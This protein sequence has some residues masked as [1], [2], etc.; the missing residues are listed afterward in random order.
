MVYVIL[1]GK[2]SFAY[3][4]VAKKLETII[5]ELGYG[6]K[7]KANEDGSLPTMAIVEL[8]SKEPKV[9][10]IVGKFANITRAF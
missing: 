9:M 7:L 2:G 4:T 8:I 10:D 6:D 3:K 1:T 5:K